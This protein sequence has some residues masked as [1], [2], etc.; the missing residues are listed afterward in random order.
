MTKLGSDGVFPML[1]TL[2]RKHWK[3]ICVMRTGP[4]TSLRVIELCNVVAGPFAGSLLADW[5]ADVIKIEMP[6]KGDSF[7]AFLPYDASHTVSLRWITMGRNKRCVTLDL[8]GEKGHRLLLD[9]VRGADLVIEN[10]RPGTLEKWGIGYDAMKAVNPKVVLVRISGYGQTGPYRAKAGLGT[11]ITAYSGFT[12]I[13]GYPDRA[14]VSPGVPLADLMAGMYAVMGGLSAVM[15]V[16]R[17]G[18]EGQVVDVAL[19]EPL[20]RTMEDKIT[21]WSVNRELPKRE[22][23]YTGAASPANYY[24]GSDGKWFV[25]A[26][27]TQNTWARMPEAMGMPEL[28]NDPRF[29]T[30]TDRVAHHEELDAII[31]GWSSR[32]APAREVCRHLDRFG[33]P[34]TPINEIS[35]I[36]EDEQMIARESLKHVEHPVLGD[37]VIPGIFPLYSG[38]PCKIDH[39]GPEMG[40][41]N[42]EVYGGELHLSAEELAQLRAEHVI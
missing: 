21:N 30:N 13:H 17:D 29:L 14:P 7:R 20:I 33:I 25:I 22:P 34:A 11:P 27:S 16:I 32:F 42:E 12:G 24:H 36:F 5:G 9:L 6:G 2:C 28:L 15:H 4:L 8:H 3:G 23:L 18:G 19:Y 38:T 26:A 35:D 40:S 41:S 37:V 31:D 10:F 1:L 39:L